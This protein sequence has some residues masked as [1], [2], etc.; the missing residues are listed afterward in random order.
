MYQ[1]KARLG[2]C[3]I[4]NINKLCQISGQAHAGTAGLILLALQTEAG[5]ATA[6]ERA[7]A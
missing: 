6:H 3:I 2:V 7:T 5:R 1:W 4:M